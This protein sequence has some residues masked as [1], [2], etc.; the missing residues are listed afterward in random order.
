M[1]VL[2]SPE[3]ELFLD[4][5]VRF[6]GERE[7]QPSSSSSGSPRLNVLEIE[8]LGHVQAALLR[9]DPKSRMRL[10]GSVA[11]GLRLRN[12]DIDISWETSL[13]RDIALRTLTGFLDEAPELFHAIHRASR[14]VPVVIV[15]DL[16]SNL[17]AEV[18]VR[19]LGAVANS[20]MIARYCN[21]DKRVRTLCTFVKYWASRRVPPSCRKGMSA[22]CAV[23]LVLHFLIKK[24]GLSSW[25]EMLSAVENLGDLPNNPA[26][27]VA[28]FFEFYSRF[29]FG[30]TA[31]CIRKNRSVS[32]DQAAA[33]CCR[34]SPFEQNKKE[35]EREAAEQ[36]RDASSVVPL[37]AQQKGADVSLSQDIEGSLSAGGDGG[38]TT[39]GVPP[40]S[41]CSLTLEDP[42]SSSAVS[43]GGGG[44][45][46]T[47]SGN[48]AEAVDSSSASSS[49]SSSCSAVTSSSS[50]CSSSSCSASGGIGLGGMGGMFV[51][52]P[53]IDRNVAETLDAVNTRVLLEEMRRAAL[54]LSPLLHPEPPEGVKKKEQRGAVSSPPDA[55]EGVGVGGAASDSSPSPET[56]EK[57]S[58]ETGG[59]GG[60]FVELL[61]VLCEPSVEAKNATPAPVDPLFLPPRPSVSSSEVADKEKEKQ[62]GE[63]CQTQISLLENVSEKNERK[64]S[65]M[66]KEPKCPLAGEEETEDPAEKGEMEVTELLVSSAAGCGRVGVPFASCVQYDAVDWGDHLKEKEK[67]RGTGMPPQEEEENE[68][69]GEGEGG[70]EGEEDVSAV[71]PVPLAI[72]RP[73]LCSSELKSPLSLQHEVAMLKHVQATLTERVRL[74]RSENAGLSVALCVLTGSVPPQQ[75]AIGSGSN[76]MQN[77]NVPSVMHS[78]SEW[79][80]GSGGWQGGG[81]GSQHWG[82]GHGGDAASSGYQHRHPQ[83]WL[84]YAKSWYGRRHVRPLSSGGGAGGGACEESGEARQGSVSSSSSSNNGWKGSR[85]GG[86]SGSWH[87]R[88]REKGGWGGSGHREGD[89]REMGKGGGKHGGG[90]RWGGRGGEVHPPMQNRPPSFPPT[91]TGTFPPV[92]AEREKEKDSVNALGE[93][94]GCR[95]ASRSQAHEGGDVS[96]VLPRIPEIEVEPSEVIAEEEKDALVEVQKEGGQ[97]A[98]G[99]RRTVSV[100]VD[101]ATG[102]PPSPHPPAP[103]ADAAVIVATRAEKTPAFPPRPSSATLKAALAERQREKKEKKEKTSSDVSRNLKEADGCTRN[104]LLSPARGAEGK[105]EEG[106]ETANSQMSLEEE[107]TGKETKGGSGLTENY[108]NL[109]SGSAVMSPSSETVCALEGAPSDCVLSRDTSVTVPRHDLSVLALKSTETSETVVEISQTINQKKVPSSS[110][111]RQ[112]GKDQRGL[113]S[114]DYSTPTAT[115]QHRGSSSQNGL[116]RN[117]GDLVR[118]DTHGSA[119]STA[120]PVASSR[121]GREGEGDHGTVTASASEEH[122]HD[123]DQ[124]SSEDASHSAAERSRVPPPPPISSTDSSG[125][126]LPSSSSSSSSSSSKGPPPLV[127][128]PIPIRNGRLPGSGPAPEAGDAVEAPESLGSMGRRAR[129]TLEEGRETPSNVLTADSP[130]FVPL[131]QTDPWFFTPQ[132]AP[133]PHPHRQPSTPHTLT[134]SRFQFTSDALHAPVFLPRAVR[135]VRL[136]MST[137]R[138]SSPAVARRLR[139]ARRSA[140]GGASPALLSSS[141]GSSSSSSE[142]ERTAPHPLATD[143]RSVTATADGLLLHDPC[144]FRYRPRAGSVDGYWAAG[145]SQLGVVGGMTMRSGCVAPTPVGHHG[146][147]MMR[148]AGGKPRL[149][150]CVQGGA[151]RNAFKSPVCVP[152][153]VAGDASK[154]SGKERRGVGRTE[155]SCQPVAT[156]VSDKG[157]GGKGGSKGKPAALVGTEEGGGKGAGA[158][159][160]KRG[161]KERK[162]GSKTPKASASSHQTPL[163]A[164]CG[165]SSSGQGAPSSSRLCFSV[166]APAPLSGSGLPTPLEG[167]LEGLGGAALEEAP[168]PTYCLSGSSSVLFSHAGGEGEGERVSSRNTVLPPPATP[169]VPPT[170]SGLVLYDLPSAGSDATPIPSRRT[171]GEQ[172]DEIVRRSAEKERG[173]T[174]LGDEE[175]EMKRLCAMKVPQLQPLQGGVGCR[176]ERG[177]AKERV[178]P[179]VSGRDSVAKEKERPS[180]SCSAEQTRR[181]RDEKGQANQA[182]QCPAPPATKR[183][184]SALPTEGKGNLPL[185]HDCVLSSVGQSSEAP[186]RPPDLPSGQGQGA[187]SSSS[188]ASGSAG[189]GIGCGDSSRSRGGHEMRPSEHERRSAHHQGGRAPRDPQSHSLHSSSPFQSSSSGL[190]GGAGGHSSGSGH[191]NG[192]G[193]VMLDGRGRLWQWC[194]KKKQQQP[195]PLQQQQHQ[196]GKEGEK[197][198]SKKMEATSGQEIEEKREAV[199]ETQGERERETD[200]CFFESEK[201]KLGAS[202][203]PGG[204]KGEKNAAGKERTEEVSSSL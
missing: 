173:K 105:S 40:S 186:P 78:S 18:T 42:F 121:R 128:L 11:T 48:P 202:M 160:T 182:S 28:G 171:I 22:Y 32:L 141:G 192:N 67:E 93:S 72:D 89:G 188:S 6:P 197:G 15:T 76:P 80:G 201:E 154:S 9:A 82:H 10:H 86:W 51:R 69:E 144:N 85:W 91:P 174:N 189:R 44:D 31:V 63:T 180:P 4:Q 119:T 56:P 142:D 143:P 138:E 97:E 75:A 41:S 118:D 120:T 88:D 52:D 39:A 149:R 8:F 199:V 61:R 132:F 127:P 193:S 139:A 172:L 47:P 33:V 94:G 92:A 7:E 3:L 65:L 134:Q 19:N 200:G 13:P 136:D 191:G 109:L 23:L 125:T 34:A 108:K 103:S 27:L 74:L 62:S 165:Q 73:T 24:H 140:E 190:G 167:P 168:T 178:S 126:P 179:A 81:R 113:T 203:D 176:K 30:K 43:V 137:V 98:S 5:D 60:S 146:G 112:D 70:K 79:S 84:K 181:S 77:A 198:G 21:M 187:A 162:G 49:S 55:L 14:R 38:D 151:S 204:E 36:Q 110:P 100:E 175:E 169:E 54:M 58:G 66:A 164:R 50:S 183:G 83:P 145:L 102:L 135:T 147:E 2:S 156:P 116:S 87:D 96:L 46:S 159:T 107:A 99:P 184:P 57:G 59:K 90:K 29:D 37:A 122:D 20:E 129:R 152:T 150:K 124:E 12:S 45:P 17:Q 117:R 185:S 148:A 194:V 130:P 131:V 195:V 155:N 111:F 68:A 114:D 177:G 25:E 104:M 166:P 133:A 16:V 161:K 1:A 157:G 153:A 170:G 106:L 196:Q 26:A 35:R 53:F 123:P 158:S 71:P 163:K 95:P 64:D 115:R 101:T